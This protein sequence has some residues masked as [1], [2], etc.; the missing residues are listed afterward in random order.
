MDKYTIE[1]G[2]EIRRNGRSFVSVVGCARFLAGYAPADFDTFARFI[3]AAIDAL[4]L[5]STSHTQGTDAWPAIVAADAAL[6]LLPESEENLPVPRVKVR[7]AKLRP[8][9][10]HS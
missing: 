4:R 9:R 6:A 7:V 3:P 2:R 1:A 8:S 10:K 5:L